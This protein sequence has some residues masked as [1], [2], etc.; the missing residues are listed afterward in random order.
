MP[1]IKFCYLVNEKT[2]VSVGGLCKTPHSWRVQLTWKKETVV[3]TTNKKGL[4][5]NFNS[6]AI[7]TKLSKFKNKNGITNLQVKGDLLIWKLKLIWEATV[8]TEESCET[9]R[10]LKALRPNWELDRI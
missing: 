3:I 1:C 9:L 8:E 2:T 10:K 7:K 5:I 6:K 4:H